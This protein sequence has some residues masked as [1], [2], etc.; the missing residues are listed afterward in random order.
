MDEETKAQFEAIAARIDAVMTR[1]D[2]QFER[3][4]DILVLLRAD[5]DNTKG[6]LLED[7]TIMGHRA[8]IIENRLAGARV[9]MVSAVAEL[10]PISFGQG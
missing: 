9:A 5:F 8:L 7:A 4:L 2:D 10:I 3:V 6:F 1:M